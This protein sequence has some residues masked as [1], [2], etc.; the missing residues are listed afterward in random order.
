MFTHLHVHSNFSLLESSIRPEDMINRARSLG[1]SSI[2]LTDK[3]TMHGAVQF[4]KLA[5]AAG[6]K[7]VT[8]CEICLFDNRCLSHLV[9]LVKNGTGYENMCRILS[10]SYANR[11]NSGK[12]STADIGG[13]G[14]DNN[15]RV[16]F[17]EL[18]DLEKFSA[19]LV[20]LSG[21]S[22]G[23]LSL[24]IRKKD[25]DGAKNFIRRLYGIFGKDF[26]AEIQ[27]YR[28]SVYN[29]IGTPGY[30][31]GSLEKN[32][33]MLPV[34]ENIR[35]FA[36]LLKIPLVATN[37][38]HYLTRSDY[39]IYGRLAR[40]K[41]MGTNTDP[42]FEIIEN[43]EHYLKSP[44]EMAELFR[45]IPQAIKNTQEI[46]EKCC[47]DFELKKSNLPAFQT[48]EDQD[49]DSYLRKICIQGLEFR[50]GNNPDKKI[51]ER[52]FN[53]LSVIKKTGF[54]GY[55]LIVADIARFAYESNI[56]ICGKGSAAGS[57]VSYVLRIS[58]IDP[59]ANNLYF[60]RFLNEE[61]RE[62]P[63]IDI[64]VSSRDRVR[65]WH[66]LQTKYGP[67]GVARVASFSTTKPRSS[68]REAARL[69]NAP[70]EE[71]DYII[72]NSSL[73]ENKLFYKKSGKNTFSIAGPGNSNTSSTM[74]Y[75]EML[76]VAEDIRGYVRHVSTHPSAFVVSS[77]CLSGKIPLAFSETGELM[78]QFDMNSIN[79]LGILKID[80][81]NSLS[82]S[83]IADVLSL[84]REKRHIN[85]DLP[86]LPC[87]DPDVFGL[88]QRGSTL[89][90][91]QL[92][93]FGIRT[94]SRKIK[95]SS[96]NDITLLISLYRP[97]PQQSGMVKNFIERKFGRERVSYIHNDL[98]PILE[99]TYGV[100][101]YQEQAMQVAIKIAGY[102]FSEADD[103]RKAMVNLSEEKM[104]AQKNRFIRGGLAKGHG[105][106]TLEEIFFLISRFASYAFVK[107]HAAAYA[108]ISYRTCYLKLHF[109]AEF[110]ATVLT[111]NSGYYSKM[112]YI[113]EARRLGV[114]LKLPDINE[115]S[116]NFE[117]GD[118]GGSIRVPLISV[119]NL[120]P[121][122]AG[123]IMS[124]REKNG[125]FLD[126]TDFC[127]RMLHSKEHGINGTAVENL[128][129]IGAF[130]FTS[131]PR[132]NLL[133]IFCLMK[134]MKKER[135][136][137]LG[138]G[139][140]DLKLCISD[141]TLEEK[142]ELEMKI[143]GFYI[144]DNP[145]RSLKKNL[146]GPDYL[147]DRIIGSSLFY[148][149]CPGDVMTA[150]IIIT[151][152]TEKTKNGQIMMFCT[153]E[154]EDGMYE[155]VLFPDVYRKYS[156]MITENP[157]VIIR[158]RLCSRDNN[159]SLIVRDVQNIR[160]LAM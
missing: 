78:S 137:T 142:L 19:G 132:K 16:P 99:E 105:R 30:Y 91:F 101:L 127:K 41:S 31:R 75:S 153:L 154:D 65:I 59:V 84:I 51:T 144:S 8:G 67:E 17:I 136:G 122:H 80:L 52:L 62:P 9:M 97:G 103:L 53:E 93:S 3:Y 120:G 134:K 71:T 139:L 35:N 5:K 125:K 131:K 6:I 133:F 76:D 85:I 34:S 138:A 157:F 66:Y 64:D 149:Y 13:G 160:S 116:L 102:T 58:N 143:L 68:L 87:D 104:L 55:F 156:K 150:G 126:F 90:V 44:R 151:K 18:D 40:I 60:E 48:P 11:D 23:M 72:K 15:T 89:G 112:Q 106:K 26:Y 109:P 70:K 81:I 110:I 82:L 108:E 123:S 73:A 119:K 98:K 147:P 57:L 95:P 61:R 100:M 1:F 4:Y 14:A 33:P 10:R 111:N 135:A 83:L 129:K 113:E 121:S 158:G 50:F 145:L 140:P 148:R 54:S 22:R 94:L 92:E 42:V 79:D 37:D 7:P 159:I 12:T 25:L 118:D 69:I 88:M 39:R 20:C 128:I 86:N 141:F 114:E 43:D 47:F 32:F 29:R 21:C 28:F 45:D 124:E 24:L 146:A 63:D 155:A 77:F 117:A 49:Q 152:R 27:R 36:Q 56:P 115:S 2:A 74:Q 38:V 96:L 107:A 46:A 130:D